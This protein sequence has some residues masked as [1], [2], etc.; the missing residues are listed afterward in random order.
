MD[1]ASDI[2]FADIAHE[3]LRGRVTPFIGAG[4]NGALRPQ[5]ATWD[6]QSAF[7]PDGG[8]LAGHLVARF[9]LDPPR[10]GE[11]PDLLRTAQQVAVQKDT[12]MLYDALSEVFHHDV[13]PTDVHRFIARAQP[14]LRAGGRS[15]QV[16]VTT[17]YDDLMERALQQEGEA[18]DVVW[19]QA[20]PKHKMRGRFF[21]QRWDPEVEAFAPA[22]SAAVR[23]PTNWAEADLG[24]RATVLKVHG[25]I[26]RQAEDGDSYV[27]TE[28]DYIDYMAVGD[29]LRQIPSVLVAPMQTGRVL[30]LGYSLKDWNLRVILRGIIGRQELDTDWW[31]VQVDVS[32]LERRFWEARGRVRLFDHPL[33]A[34]IS[35]LREEIGEPAEPR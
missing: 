23:S 19:Y 27:I 18:F 15:C 6:P 24:R 16:I 35:R 8:E 13:A 10:A 9:R 7:L 28:D 31:S 34:F 33:D 26:D 29:V 2:P 14:I 4:V 22:E 32:E 20:R 11:T 17:N 25:A 12:R 3:L 1:D 5:G 21:H 30:F